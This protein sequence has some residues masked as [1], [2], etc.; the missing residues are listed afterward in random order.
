MPNPPWESRS[1]MEVDKEEEWE[2]EL[3]RMEAEMYQGMANASRASGIEVEMV[4]TQ[5]T[6]SSRQPRKLGSP[7][8]HLSSLSRAPS[9]CQC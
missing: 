3:N 4:Y 8:V 6:N 2:Q 1:V 9:C 5:E 7:V